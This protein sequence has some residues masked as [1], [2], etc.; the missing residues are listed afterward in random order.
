LI[1]FDQVANIANQSEF[2]HVLT[3]IIK[4]VYLPRGAMLLMNA[5]FSDTKISI[6]YLFAKNLSKLIVIMGVFDFSISLS[7]IFSQLGG[8]LFLAWV[9]V[10]SFSR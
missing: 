10:F 1:H 2:I 9:T 7:P 5:I 4:L 6:I 3:I 8:L